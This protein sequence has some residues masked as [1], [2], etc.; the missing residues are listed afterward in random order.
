MLA[1]K[2]KMLFIF[3]LDSRRGADPTAPR[4]PEGT[5]PVPHPHPESGPALLPPTSA[6][7]RCRCGS[8]LA[9]LVSGGVELKC[10]RCKRTVVVPLAPPSRR[11][12]LRSPAAPE[13]RP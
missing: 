10:R 4:E 1:A 13:P 11:R 8:L 5:P 3:A 12:G 6:D 7:C 9:R 2:M